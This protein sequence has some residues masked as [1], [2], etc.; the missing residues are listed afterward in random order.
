MR[1]EIDQHA[2]P[3]KAQEK[4]QAP[5][6]KREKHRVS[7]IGLAASRSQGLERRCR[8]QGHDRD[9]AGCQLTARPEQRGDQRRQEGGIQ[10]VVGGEPGQLRISHRLGHQDEAHGRPR[11]QVDA[12]GG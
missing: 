4:L 5:D 11:H 2:Q 9:R 8:H 10:A 7:D 3:E 12:E 6:E 1:E